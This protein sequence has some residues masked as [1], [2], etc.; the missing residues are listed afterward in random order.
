MRPPVHLLEV[1]GC[2]HDAAEE[3]QP[4]VR[5]VFGSGDGHP[6]SVPTLS[7]LDDSKTQRP[8][9]NIGWV[10]GGADHTR[11]VQPNSPSLATNHILYFSS[12][13]QCV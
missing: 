2:L 11:H 8:K 10:G 3:I 6:A 4:A 7:L 13:F 5:P 1:P 12:T 9:P